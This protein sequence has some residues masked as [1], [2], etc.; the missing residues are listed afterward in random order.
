MKIAGRFR[1]SVLLIVFMMFLPAAVYAEGTEAAAPEYS[2]KSSW[3]YFADGADTG[4][5]VFLLSPTVDYNDEL[6][7]TLDDAMKTKFLTGISMEKPVYDGAGRIYAPYYRQM[8]LAAYRYAFAEDKTQYVQA[9]NL[10][11]SD[12]SAAFRY[13]LDHENNGRG[14]IL[15]GFSQG[16][17]MCLELLKEYY[18]GDSEEA[19]TLRKNLVSVYAIGWRLSQDTVDQYPQIVPATGEYDI[20]SIV[21]YDCENGELEST[22]IIPAGTK[23]LSI[24]PLNWKTDETEAD[25]SLNL[26]ALMLTTKEI[27]PGLC[28]AKIGSRGELIVTGVNTADFPPTIGGVTTTFFPEGHFHI[29]DYAF[30]LVNLKK[31]VLTRSEVWRKATQTKIT[32]DVG[33]EAVASGWANYLNGENGLPGCNAKDSETKVTLYYPREG[34]TV[35]DVQK[36]LSD[37]FLAYLAAEEEALENDGVRYLKPNAIGQKEITTY[38]SSEEIADEVAAPSVSLSEEQTFYALYERAITHVKLD[39][40]VPERDTE[41]TVDESGKQSPLPQVQ[42]TYPKA[43]NDS[44]GNPD[45]IKIK[46]VFW[47]KEKNVTE[48]N[49]FT[50]NLTEGSIANGDAIA[51]ISLDTAFGYYLKLD[52]DNPGIEVNNEKIRDEDYFNKDSQTEKGF[53]YQMKITEIKLELGKNH[54][55]LANKWVDY[56]NSE[57]SDIKNYGAGTENDTVLVKY[58]NQ[59]NTLRK[60]RTAFGLSLI[61]LLNETNGKDNNEILMDYVFVQMP[62]ENYNSTE[63]IE[64]EIDEHQNDPLENGMTLYAIW[65]DKA[66]SSVDVAIGS[67]V[68]G[69]PATLSRISISDEHVLLTYVDWYDDQWE[70]IEGKKFEGEKTYMATLSFGPAFGYYL[71]KDIE[72]NLTGASFA[73][74]KDKPSVANDGM[75]MFFNA[76]VKSEH[77]WDKGKITTQPTTEKEGVKTFTCEACGAT[78]TEA[79]DKLS[80]TTPDNPVNPVKPVNPTAKEVLD[81]KLP[82]I[83]IKKPVAKKKGFTA[84]WKKLSKKNRKKVGGIEIQYARNKKFTTSVKIVTAKKTDTSKKINKLAKKKTYYVRIRTYKKVGNVKH[85]SKWSKVRK[86]KT[87]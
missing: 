26:G 7:A 77:K 41:V 72:V 86:V 62:P 74:G 8:A 1:L 69:N 31:N 61:M 66:I 28:G 67:P 50:G 22:M 39:L 36:I 48:N 87:K 53:W 68:C 59:D 73:G 42:V 47:A 25:K 4:V 82:K 10:A 45:K 18:G 35:T 27:I 51:S 75:H 49:L 79:V 29:Y 33:R 56:L 37:N 40:K 84:K 65:A 9:M 24:N 34:K 23:A 38:N 85:F 71:D 83:T 55:E 3:A 21:S 43:V 57:D 13:Y 30:Y 58:V 16:A 5:D 19:V 44:V 17:Q 81:T 70:S 64:R 60:A 80:P 63:M 11:Y 52:G 15:A 78:K 20:G 54:V 14:I 12:V 76:E 6:N 46:E 32:V 2:D